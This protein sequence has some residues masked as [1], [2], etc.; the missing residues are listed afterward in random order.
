MVKVLEGK[1]SR[2]DLTI[3]D[4]EILNNT[5]FP[6]YWLEKPVTEEYPC[7]SHVIIPRYNYKTNEGFVVNSPSFDF[8]KS[9]FNKFCKSKKIKVNRIL[10]A[11][12]NLIWNFKGTYSVP[13][14][15]HDFKHKICIMYLNDCTEGSTFLFKEKHPL[16]KGKN[17][18]K[19]IK[20]KKG[21]IVIFPGENLH[22]SGFPKKENERRMICIISFD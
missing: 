8:F 21:K 22:A 12:L 14:V 15:D 1:I 17:I 13:H 20:S 16:D 2:S 3:I 9:V 10:R 7:M 6:W 18:A 19:E 11:Q 4:K 5:H